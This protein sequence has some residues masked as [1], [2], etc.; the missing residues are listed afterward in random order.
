M[1]KSEKKSQIR[2]QIAVVLFLLAII[3][4]LLVSM[5]SSKSERYWA[6]ARPIPAGSKIAFDDIKEMEMHLDTNQHD[7]VTSTTNL[8]GMV[9]TRSFLAN[10]AV[11][12]RYFRDTAESSLEEVSIAVAANDIPMKTNVGDYVSIYLLQDAQNGEGASPPSR[13][14]AGV[15]ISELDRKGSNFGNTISVTL[16]LNQE[17]VP[18]LLAASS[19]G[20]LVL[21]GKNG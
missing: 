17:L 7:F 2:F 9:T 12:I 21:V 1:S 8:I 14:L 20:R 6:I 11:D 18:R 16:S 5:T 3:T 19:Q 10:E 13:V 15:F 4:P